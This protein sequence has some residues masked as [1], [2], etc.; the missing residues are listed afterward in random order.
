MQGCSLIPECSG[1]RCPR[2]RNVPGRGPRPD[3][4]TGVEFL[5]QWFLP[6]TESSKNSL[7]GARSPTKPYEAA[8]RY[9]R[10]GEEVNGGDVSYAVVNV[11]LPGLGWWLAVA[12]HVLL[13]R[14]LGD[15]CPQQRQYVD[16][17]RRAVE[18]ILARHSSDQLPDLAIDS[19]PPRVTRP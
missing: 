8:E 16:D 19:W 2:N 9:R 3:K 12:D 18:P 4:A 6:S 10:G 17:P 15:M 14:G 5:V 7:P 11:D 1:F 13:D